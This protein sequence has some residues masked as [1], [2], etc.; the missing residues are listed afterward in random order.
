M[1][2]LLQDIFKEATGPKLATLRKS[3]QDA[4][5]ILCMQESSHKRPSC[6][7]RKACLLPLQI[8]LESKRPKLVSFALSGFHKIL[9][10]DRF[11]RGIEPEDD[12]LW[13][14]SQLLCSTASVMYHTPDTQVQ[15]FRMYLSLALSPRRTLNGRLAVWACGRCAEAAAAPAP[16]AAAAR[17]AAAQTLRAYTAQLDEECQELLSEGATLDRNH[18]VAVGCY[19]EV[20]PVIQYLCGRLSETQLEHEGHLVDDSGRGSGALV[21]APS[22]NSKQAKAVYSIANQLV[23]LVGSTSNLRPVLEALYHRMLLYPPISHRTEPLRSVRELLQNPKR[24][25]QLI[26]LKKCEQGYEKHSDDM[27][28]IRL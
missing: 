10:D 8:A 19:S 25:C 4:L 24:L 15:I 1:E 11:H 12:S 13:L 14:P 26:L 28:I 17:A 21:C 20:I 7:V 2:E 9:R 5:E 18:I 27:A 22:F 3:C 16:V 6:E 23:R